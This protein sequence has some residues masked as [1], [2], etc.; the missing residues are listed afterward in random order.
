MGTMDLNV[1]YLFKVS[2]DVAFNIDWIC[3]VL[4]V[5][6][7]VEKTVSVSVIVIMSIL[8]DEASRPSQMPHNVQK[9][10]LIVFHRRFGHRS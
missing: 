5:S 3:N 2:G 9:G 4:V 8:D 7:R 1:C 10:T 6:C